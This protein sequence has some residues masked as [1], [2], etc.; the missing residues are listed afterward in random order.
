MKGF[1]VAPVQNLSDALDSDNEVLEIKID[2]HKKE[3]PKE[4]FQRV[5][6]TV[7]SQSTCYK[8]NEVLRGVAKNS[9]IGRCANRTSFKNLQQLSKAIEE[10]KR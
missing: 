5:A 10:A 3:T 9:Q 1:Q 2:S 4:R 7:A 8:W 6:R